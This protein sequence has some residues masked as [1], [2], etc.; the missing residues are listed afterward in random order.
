MFSTRILDSVVRREVLA[1]LCREWR[2]YPYSSWC[3]TTALIIVRWYIFA[4]DSVRHAAGRRHPCKPLQGAIGTS[5]VLTGCAIIARIIY[6]YCSNT[7]LF[8]CLHLEGR[9][10]ASMVC[11]RI[12]LQKLYLQYSKHL[13]HAALVHEDHEAICALSW[14]FIVK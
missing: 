8:K 1:S 13:K 5:A 11:S 3:G 7:H 6:L 2:V 9:G 10:L 12:D 4:R 14:S